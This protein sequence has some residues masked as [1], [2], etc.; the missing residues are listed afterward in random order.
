M[1]LTSSALT[2]FFLVYLG[3]TCLLGGVSGFIIS[4]VLRLRWKPAI[5]LQDMAISGVTPLLFAVVVTEIE[6]NRLTPIE[7]GEVHHSFWT[8]VFI[9]FA[10]IVVRHLIRFLSLRTSSAISRA[11]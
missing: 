8:L 10:A 9:G 5:F 11:R 1:V 6:A 2:I 3:L 4:R 7:R